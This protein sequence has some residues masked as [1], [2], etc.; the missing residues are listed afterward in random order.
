MASVV[1]LLATV[2]ASPPLPRDVLESP[3]GIVNPWPEVGAKGMGAVWCRCGGGATSLGDWPSIQPLAGVFRWEAADAEMRVYEEEGLVPCPILSYTPEWASRAPG[4]KDASARPPLSLRDYFRFCREMAARYAGRVW[5]WEIWNE[6]NIG[7]FE[8]TAADYADLLKA[9][10]LG[11]LAGNPKAYVVFGGMAGVDRPFLDLCY[12]HGVADYFDVMAAHPY[13]WGTTFNDGWFFDKLEMLRATMSAWADGPKPIW[14]NEV[15][16][17]TGDPG[18]TEEI[19]ARLLV[20]CFVSALS[21]EDLG[22]ER[23]F[24]YCVKDWG[25]PGHGVYADDGHKKPAWYAYQTMTRSLR[26]LKYL[27]RIQVGEPARAYVFG[28]AGDRAVVVVWSSDLEEHEISLPLGAEAVSAW[29]AMGNGLECGQYA[30]GRL[31][32]VARP[33]PTYVE[34]PKSALRDVEQ[35]KPLAVSLPDPARRPRG[36]LSLYPQ[37]GCEMPWLWRGH[38]VSLSGRLVNTGDKAVRG[39]VVAVLSTDDGRELAK[40][41]TP[42][43]AEPLTDTRFAVN[44]ACPKEAPEEATLTLRAEL[45]SLRLPALKLHVLIGDGPTVNFLANSHLERSIYL[46]P[47]AESGCAESVRFGSRWVYRIPVPYACRVVV[48][49]DV[50]A[51]QAGPWSVAWSQD[52]KEWRPLMSGKSDRQWHSAKVDDLKPGRLYLKCEGQDQQVGQVRV[53]FITATP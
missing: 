26:G 14:L 9:G 53:T 25:G 3:F 7:F 45:S 28:G 33:Q 17:S 44:V 2:L 12:Q 50:G 32:M 23:V 48:R 38:T 40:A 6:P 11:V 35:V 1:L 13:Q 18:I 52:G 10:A 31:T 42:V 43:A 30:A 15:G 39:Q 16:W 22:V 8:G 36:W 20:Q 5:F 34:V 4:S 51:H 19:Q 24:W 41:Q 49:M 37:P 21:R 27:G 47:D 29:D 46:Q